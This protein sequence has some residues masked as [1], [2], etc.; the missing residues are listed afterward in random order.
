MEHSLLQN[1][2]CFTCTSPAS[3][4]TP[5]PLAL[6]SEKIRVQ[7]LLH[8]NT[9]LKVLSGNRS[10]NK[11]WGKKKNTLI[12]KS[13][14]C[15]NE[16]KKKRTTGGRRRSPLG[17]DAVSVRRW[18]VALPAAGGCCRAQRLPRSD[19][20]GYGQRPG[21]PHSHEW[22]RGG[23]A[24]LSGRTSFPGSR[25]LRGAVRGSPSP[26]CSRVPGAFF[27]CTERLWR[28]GGCRGPG[29]SH[30]Q[31]RAPAALGSA[32]APC[33]AGWGQAALNNGHVCGNMV[34]P[35]NAE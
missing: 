26:P 19:P 35:N 14:R 34:S 21:T 24:P 33:G 8:P 9:Q 13:K 10:C 7:V 1:Q 30:G 15:K 25:L 20:S 12:L 5:T 16:G 4:L 22:R 2:H 31:R 23:E 6:K 11:S 18:C 17:S 27:R 28:A 3:N 29:A 32:P